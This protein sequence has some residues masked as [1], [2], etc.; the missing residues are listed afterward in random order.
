MSTRMN[1]PQENKNEV[2]H[3]FDVHILAGRMRIEK[4]SFNVF[5]D[6]GGYSVVA[7]VLSW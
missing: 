6:E 2:I 3:N 5:D 7:I 1:Q 4:Y